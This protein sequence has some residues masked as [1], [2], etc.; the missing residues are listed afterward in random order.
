MLKKI[1]KI[2]VLL[3]SILPS[4]ALRVAG[5]RA[6]LGY[7][8]GAGARLG[9]GVAILVDRFDCGAGV[10]IRRGTSFF[11][12]IRVT[13]G[14]HTFIGRF[15][16]IECGDNA[17]DAANAHMNYAREFITG[18]DS[19]INES[20]LFDVLG[21]IRIG[22]GTWVAGFGSQF[23]THGAGTMNRDIAI[24]AQCFIGSAVR[25]APGSGVGNRVV[26]GMGAVVTKRIEQDDVVVGGLPAKIIKNRSEE[27]G[28]V[29]QKGW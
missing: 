4:S 13:L 2:L 25:F 10:V 24:G 17:G 21:Q 22:D 3:I 19:L 11:G 29:F 14:D 6:L 28:Y 8:F 20:H 12:P 9:W 1:K 18:R 16:K 7:R 27:D 15:N 5:Y 26:V 23:L